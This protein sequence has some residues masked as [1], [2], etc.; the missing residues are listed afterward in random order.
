M[1]CGDLT[2]TSCRAKLLKKSRRGLKPRGI[3][4]G[5]SM[6]GTWWPQ[7]RCRNGGGYGDE[8]PM[9]LGQQNGYDSHASLRQQR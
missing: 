5:L 3:F 4:P 7:W 6:S 8:G 9:P 1:P 2:V